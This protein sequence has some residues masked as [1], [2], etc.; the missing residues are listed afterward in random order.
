VGFAIEGCEIKLGDDDELLVR[1]PNVFAGYWQREEATKAAFT[2]DGWFRT[3]DQASIDER[4]R[5]AIIGRVKNI[6]VPESG[7]NVAPEPIE[8]RLLEGVPG[9]VQAVVV[10]HRS[11]EHTSELQSREKLVWRSLVDKKQ[12]QEKRAR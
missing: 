4:G 8:T 10:G 3:G 1:G 6:I 11:E 5:V 12:Q 9:L 2:E 7:H